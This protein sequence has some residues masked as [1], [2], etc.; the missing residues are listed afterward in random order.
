M[1][2]RFGAAPI[3]LLCRTNVRCRTRAAGYDGPWVMGL[4]RM[5]F[6]IT[7]GLKVIAPRS[8][9]DLQNLDSKRQPTLRDREDYAAHSADNASAC[10]RTFC[11]AASC[12]SG[13]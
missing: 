4:D 2:A 5:A 3:G 13:G 1:V 10:C 7:D 11:T 8:I 12:K 6:E 9:D